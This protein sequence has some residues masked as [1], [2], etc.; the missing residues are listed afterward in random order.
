MHNWKS[1]GNLRKKKTFLERRIWCSF[2]IRQSESQELQKR[3]R[4]KHRGLRA[5]TNENEKL[6]LTSYIF[7]IGVSPAYTQA[8]SLLGQCN[9]PIFYIEHGYCLNLRL[10]LHYVARYCFFQLRTSVL[11]CECSAAAHEQFHSCSHHV[12]QLCMPQ[13]FNA[14]LAVGRPLTRWR[15]ILSSLRIS[16]AILEALALS[17]NVSVQKKPSRH[18][19]YEFCPQS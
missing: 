4:Y 12:T 10:Q 14:T 11:R 5:A 8:L 15:H 17:R 19:T 2:P 18:W 6:S 16:F 3:I 7:H 1:Q 9:L 13:S